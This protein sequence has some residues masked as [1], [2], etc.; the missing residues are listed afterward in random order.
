MCYN[1]IQKK[2]LVYI[3]IWLMYIICRFYFLYF[4]L[5]NKKIKCENV[6][7]KGKVK[8]YIQ[9]ESLEKSED[10]ND[11]HMR[12]IC[13]FFFFGAVGFSRLQIVERLM[14]TRIYNETHVFPLAII[15]VYFFIIIFFFFCRGQCRRVAFF[16]VEIYRISLKCVQIHTHTHT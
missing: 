5:Y 9:E 13:V 8:V 16:Y 11:T 3:Q 7:W 4:L 6:L 14:Y 15:L 12:V 2:K 10:G 1:C